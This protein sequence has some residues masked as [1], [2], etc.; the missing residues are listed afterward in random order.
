VLRVLGNAIGLAG[1][2]Y[3]N[4]EEVREEVRRACA[5][6]MPVTHAGHL[7]AR[8]AEG[9]V[10]LVDFPMYSVD[11]LVRRAPSLQRTPQGSAPPALYE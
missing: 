6:P 5:E 11:G 1:F 3:Q 2:E 10:S 7:E 8:P 4:A 9:P